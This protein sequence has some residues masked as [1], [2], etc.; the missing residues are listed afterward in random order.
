LGFKV[1][2]LIY[3]YLPFLN[4]GVG[5]LEKVKLQ[6]IFVVAIQQCEQWYK[7]KVFIAENQICLPIFTLSECRK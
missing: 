2:L 7:T 3:S 6:L 1:N 4:A 5:T